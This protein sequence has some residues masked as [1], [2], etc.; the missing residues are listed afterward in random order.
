MAPARRPRENSA[1]DEARIPGA[2]SGGPRLQI[3]S[4]RIDRS[5]IDIGTRQAMSESVAIPAIDPTMYQRN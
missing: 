2:L 3:S 5:P 1:M 4:L